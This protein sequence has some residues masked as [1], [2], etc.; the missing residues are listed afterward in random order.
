MA[1]T[2]VLLTAVAVKTKKKF[3]I[4]I[5]SGGL[6]GK[7]LGEECTADMIG[8]Q[9]VFTV[10][11][12]QYDVNVEALVKQLVMKIKLEL[13]RPKELKPGMIGM[14]RSRYPSE[15][16]LKAKAVLLTLNKKKQIGWF[17]LLGNLSCL[18][19]GDYLTEELKYFTPDKEQP[20]VKGRKRPRVRKAKS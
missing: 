8:K 6:T 14:L 18:L 16:R 3:Y 10:G 7:V 11:E 2:S 19:A 20:N 15:S 12:T 5:G 1:K 17:K 4:K 9:L 13:T